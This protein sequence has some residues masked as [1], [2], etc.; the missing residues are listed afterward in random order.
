M[1]ELELFIKEQFGIDLD[2][3]SSI[4]KESQG[5]DGYIHGAIGEQEFKQYAEKHGYEVYRIK[6]K[7]EGGYNA[8]TD[9]ARGDFYIKKKGDKSDM[10]YVVEC[11]SA[12]SNAEDR[13]LVSKDITDPKERKKKCVN[14][15]CK[16]SVNRA[17][18][19]QS[20]FNSGKKRYEKKKAAWVATHPGHVFPPFQWD[21]NNPGALFPD[22]SGLWN[23]KSDIEDW[24]NSL[25]DD[26]LSSDAFYN[27]KAPIRL[28]QTHM[29]SN[30]K[31]YVLNIKSTGP[32]VD[33]FSIL[34]VDLFRRTGKHDLV[35]ANSKDL[36]PQAGAPNRLQQNYYIDILVQKDDF[37]R[38]NLL[39]PWYDDLDEC[40]RKTKPKLRKIDKTQIDNR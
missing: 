34:C 13:F 31:D 9:D 28:I 23:K 30:R 24:V 40:I 19:V 20:S 38:H 1:E 37:T 16:Y 14:F 33:D 6:E 29:P 12:K 22:L 15:L 4:L 27:R 25:S 2:R 18:N 11:K 10:G 8:K 3:F 35:F 36:P 7:P 26:M 17:K 32:L 39:T 21:I 5:A